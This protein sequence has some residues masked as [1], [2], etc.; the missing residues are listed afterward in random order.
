MLLEKFI[1]TNTAASA[2]FPVAVL[3]NQVLLILSTIIEKIYYQLFITQT[4][5]LARKTQS[6]KTTKQIDEISWTWLNSKADIH[7]PK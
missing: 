5:L 6:V 3:I 1:S 4:D 7:L 2:I